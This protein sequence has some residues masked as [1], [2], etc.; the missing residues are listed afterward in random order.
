MRHHRNFYFFLNEQRLCFSCFLGIVIPSPFFELWQ[1]SCASN[2]SIPWFLSMVF[3][4]VCQIVSVCLVHVFLG[5]AG[6]FW[7]VGSALPPSPH[8][9]PRV[10][11]TSWEEEQGTHENI[12][13]VVLRGGFESAQC[14]PP[15]EA[16]LQRA[17][18][19]CRHQRAEPWGAGRA[20]NLERNSFGRTW[21]F[22]NS[23]ISPN[24]CAQST[25]ISVEKSSIVI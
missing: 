14:T 24:A 4:L 10:K 17:A 9:A 2:F 21:H 23:Q 18:E 8:W 13:P 15:A 5:V 20:S 3:G 1:P 16:R 12:L 11:Q 6:I 25:L 22:L 19:S 7:V